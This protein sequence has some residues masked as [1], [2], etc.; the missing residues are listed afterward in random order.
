VATTRK[1]TFKGL[2][3]KRRVISRNRRSIQGGSMLDIRR[4]MPIA[5]AV[6]YG[7]CAGNPQP[8]DPGYAYNLSG[9]YDATYIVNDEPYSGTIDLST[10]P[11]GDVTGTFL[12]G[13]P[14]LIEGSFSGVIAG[15]EFT[16][17]GPYQIAGGCGGTVSGS[18]FITEGGTLVS[19]EVQVDDEC[20]GPMLGT[21][22]FSR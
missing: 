3:R 9:T 20:G 14:D 17:S 5:V 1:P 7:A 18:G 19:G 12:L 2:R 8:G 11:G 16:Y 13:D 10:A 4:V 6:L 22:S 21:Y 15:N